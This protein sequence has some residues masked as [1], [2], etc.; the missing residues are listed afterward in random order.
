MLKVNDLLSDIL[1]SALF[2][3]HKEYEANK[4]EVRQELNDLQGKKKNVY[5][6][7]DTTNINKKGYNFL[8]LIIQVLNTAENWSGFLKK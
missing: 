3:F 1:F 6:T 4:N 8:K 5:T 2:D 7:P